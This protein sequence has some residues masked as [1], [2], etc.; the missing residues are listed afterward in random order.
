LTRPVAFFHVDLDNLWAIADCYGVRLD[1]AHEDL[2]YH[3]SL[4]RFRELLARVG[5]Q[6]TFFVL[7]RDLERERN[8]E[9]LLQLKA[10]GHVF[11]NHSYSHPLRFRAMDERAI[12]D[13]VARTEAAMFEHLESKPMG[14]RAPG[15]GVSR[16]L[17]SVLRRRGYRY[18]SS[19]APMPFGPVF[20]FMDA[21]LT[22]KLSGRRVD[23]TQYARLSDARA[24]L[25]PYRISERDLTTPDPE[26]EL[27]E[28]PASVSPLMRLPF[29]ASVC[30]QFGGWYFNLLLAAFRRRPEL[31]LV[32]LMHAADL[33]DF[34]GMRVAPFDRFGFYAK[35]IE[36]KERR[37]EWM[38]RG[39]LESHEVRL[40]EEWVDSGSLL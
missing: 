23:K 31:P 17:V 35:P 34:A 24:P 21:R 7:G 11:A 1:P 13:E 19:L 40:T 33:A 36:E 14:F 32:F 9:L 12:E 20:R 38:L 26:S 4:P 18:D 8:R 22:R 29:Q 16:A 15:Y 28:L 3:D 39:I 10:D 5:A 37:L 2:V 27:L 30:M 25:A 6:A